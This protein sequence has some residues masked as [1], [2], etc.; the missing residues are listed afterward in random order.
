MKASIITDSIDH[1]TEEAIANST[2]NLIPAN[3]VLMVI[4][5]GILKHDLPIAL[6]SVPVT[7]N[8]DMKAF[9]VS[10]RLHP[11]YLMGYFRAIERDVLLGVRAVTADNIDFK[12]F[13]KRLVPIPP[14][15]LQEQYAAFVQQ[16]DKSKFA[17]L[18]VS[19]LNLSLSLE[20]QLRTQ[21]PGRL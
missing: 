1:I 3:S 14:M 4:R 12:A 19:N 16:S 20:I 8:Q 9:V 6:N 18:N 7:I 2:T 11:Q 17:A 5:S 13:Q 15:A 10:S 21:N